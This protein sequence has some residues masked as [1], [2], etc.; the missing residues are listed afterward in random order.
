M[1]DIYVSPKRDLLVVCKGTARPILG[2]P[3]KWRKS[4]KRVVEVSDE[5]KSAVE[6]QDYL[7][8]VRE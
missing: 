8:K 5:I 6:T 4:K 3:G 1:F 7:R 2:S